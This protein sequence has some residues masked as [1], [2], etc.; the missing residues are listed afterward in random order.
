VLVVDGAQV[1][2]N[3]KA[4][5]ELRLLTNF[6]LN[7]RFLLTVVLTG[8]PELRHRSIVGIPQL[9][10]RIA[11][12]AHLGPFTAEDDVVYYGMHGRRDSPDRRVQERGGRSHLRTE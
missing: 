3:V 11:V 5:E 6:Q 2:V 4:F 7:D 10:Q 8:Q 12:R 9:N 1:I